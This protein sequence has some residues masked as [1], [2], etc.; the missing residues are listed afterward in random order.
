VKN[1]LPFILV[2]LLFVV[3]I[4]ISRRNRHRAE[5]QQTSRAERLTAGTKVMTTSGL[6]GTIIARNDDETVQLQIAPGIEV[7]WALAALRDADSLAPPFRRGIPGGG[8]QMHKRTDEDPDA[9]A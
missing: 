3:L 6:Y 8:V 7:K 2:V 9:A 4:T 5:V 1:L